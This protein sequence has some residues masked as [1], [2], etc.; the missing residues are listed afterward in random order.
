MSKQLQEIT[1]AIERQRE[2]QRNFFRLNPDI[3]L[4]T[5]H[6]WPTTFEPRRIAEE[7]AV[8]LWIKEHDE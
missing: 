3:L 4:T 2:Y 7:I 1:E 6:D 8:E 5:L